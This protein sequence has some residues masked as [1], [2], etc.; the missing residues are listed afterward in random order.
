MARRRRPS[1]LSPMYHARRAAIRRGFLGGDRAWQIFGVVYFGAKF[2]RSAL[3]K[4]TEIVSVDKLEPGQSIR[5]TAIEPKTLR[6]RS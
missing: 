4:S 2:V 6:S 5:I 3:G 1:M